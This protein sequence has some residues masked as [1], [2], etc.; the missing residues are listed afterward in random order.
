MPATY[1]ALHQRETHCP[2]VLSAINSQNGQTY[3]SDLTRD[4][5]TL[6]VMG[7]T[8][9]RRHDLSRGLEELPRR[10]PVVLI[11]LRKKFAGGGNFFAAFWQICCQI[12]LH[13]RV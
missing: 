11:R 4:G 2:A 13:G 12:I 3:R 1:A 10:S 5:F 9:N 6:L 7:W 8:G